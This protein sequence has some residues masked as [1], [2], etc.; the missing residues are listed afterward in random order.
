MT[1]TRE[2]LA[3]FNIAGLTYY[4][5]T[6]CFENLKIGTKLQLKVEQDNK[7]DARAVAIYF[8]EHKLGFVPKSENRIFYKLLIMG[9]NT[10]FEASIQQIDPTEHPECQIRV[11]IHLLKNKDL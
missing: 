3:N 4:E 11:V 1:N 7:F 6:Q 5:A 8:D 10:I 2:H 9:Y